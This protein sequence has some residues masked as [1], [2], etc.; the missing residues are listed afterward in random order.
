MFPKLSV[1]VASLIF[2]ELGRHNS[3][4]K[5]YHYVKEYGEGVDRMY[6]ELEV[7]GAAPLSF[8]TD[9]FILK[10]SVPRGTEKVT[11]NGDGVTEKL[12]ENVD[13]LIEKLIEKSIE[14]G[15][16]FTENRIAIL[17]LIAENP[18]ISKSELAESIGISVTAI[19]NNIKAMRNK[20]LRR[21]GVIRAA[22]G[23]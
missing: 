12:I 6:C 21:V 15:E 5:T 20:Y 4:V 7:N 9:D 2:S 13:R 23:K 18:Y 17:R 8:H 3:L 1:F 14:N 11:E 16:R 22:F 10:A 19:S